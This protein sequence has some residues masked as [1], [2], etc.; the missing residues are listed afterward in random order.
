MKQPILAYLLP[1]LAIIPAITGCKPTNLLTYKHRAYYSETSIIY[2]D[3]TMRLEQSV[4][5]NK[6]GTIDEEYSCLLTLT[7]KDTAAA[8]AKKILNLA[9]DTL[10][11]KARFDIVSVWNWGGDGYP[12]TGQVEI[13]TWERDKI[14]LKENVTVVHKQRNEKYQ[15][16]GVRTFNLKKPDK[17]DD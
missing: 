8:R 11:V 7:F 3:S 14:R 12:A 6:P 4:F 16:K 9:S 17:D 13:L 10:I 1:A 2:R 5:Y 15:L